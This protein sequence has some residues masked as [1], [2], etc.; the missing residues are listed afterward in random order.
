M[1]ATEEIDGARSARRRKRV[2][3]IE[4]IRNAR[5]ASETR[6]IID[7]T[8]GRFDPGV[9]HAPGPLTFDLFE[10][11]FDR[12]MALWLGAVLLGTGIAGLRRA[13]ES[14]EATS[15]G[16]PRTNRIRCI[17]ASATRLRGARSSPLPSSTS[18]VWW[19]RSRRTLI[20]KQ[21]YWAAYF[22]IAGT[23]WVLGAG[24]AA[25]RDGA[26]KNEGHERRY[27]A[28]RLAM[29]IGQ[30]ILWGMWAFLPHS[31]TMDVIKLVFLAILRLSATSRA[32]AS[33]AHGPIVPGQLA[34]SD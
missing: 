12:R 8:T 16:S 18:P 29:C 24:P 14:A 25:A 30:P 13:A 3:R 15:S 2:A 11:G 9:L 33:A 17:A 6:C 34:V 26:T 22:P 7:S 19:W 27:L 31:R 28:I 32:S 5:S 4:L 23:V 21:I 20:L 10:R 1:P